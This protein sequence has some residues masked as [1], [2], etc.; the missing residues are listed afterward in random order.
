MPSSKSTDC[1]LIRRELKKSYSRKHVKKIM[2]LMHSF[3]RKAK[4]SADKS[5]FF[6]AVKLFSQH[7]VWELEDFRNLLVAVPKGSI[8]HQFVSN[9]DESVV[10][11]QKIHHY[12]PMQFY[13]DQYN[14]RVTA[15]RSR[16]P[17]DESELA[18]LLKSVQ[19]LRQLSLVV[20]SKEC[21]GLV[22]KFVNLHE[23]N[24][25]WHGDERMVFKCPPSVQNIT[26]VGCLQ[27]RDIFYDGDRVDYRKCSINLRL[28]INAV[29]GDL[30]ILH[31]E[32]CHVDSSL[33]FRRF[34]KL[35]TVL[36]VKCTAGSQS[37]D[38]DTDPDFS[39]YQITDGPVRAKR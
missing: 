13:D 7:V 30:Q 24:L 16:E 28:D 34:E 9:W 14:V 11:G 31:L 29:Y 8:G 10:N 35:R 21:L 39:E 6:E 36:M 19:H 32:C 5:C 18:C 38:S 12:I 22:E 25:E 20:E 17:L 27:E 33:D 3:P 2:E 26:V 1:D 15:W 4:K 37:T 23:L